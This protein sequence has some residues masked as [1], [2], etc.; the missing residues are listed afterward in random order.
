MRYVNPLIG[1]DLWF[2][3]DEIEQIAAVDRIAL[4][5]WRENDYAVRFWVESGS[6]PEDRVAAECIGKEVEGSW[7][8]YGI[9]DPNR[10]RGISAKIQTWLEIHATLVAERLDCGI[11]ITVDDSPVGCLLTISLAEIECPDPD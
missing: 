11:L 9:L 7:A 4:H 10:P 1:Q 2:V 8:D 3:V 5:M 6:I